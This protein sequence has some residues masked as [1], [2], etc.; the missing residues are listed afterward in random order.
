[1]SLYVDSDEDSELDEA[2]EVESEEDI[3]VDAELEMNE[4][5]LHRAPG[6]DR[7]VHCRLRLEPGIE[8]RLAVWHVRQA[9]RAGLPMWWGHPLRL[10]RMRP[11]RHVTVVLN[12]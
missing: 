7:Q 11:E 1:M 6:G 3:D 4:E 2:E 12:N 9:F 8:L 5:V 10:Q